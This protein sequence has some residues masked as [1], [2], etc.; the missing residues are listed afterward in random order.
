MSRTFELLRSLHKDGDILP[1]NA[2]VVPP[3]D[4]QP[5]YAS[6]LQVLHP[7][8]VEKSDWWRIVDTLRRHWRLSA[9][10]T[11]I[12]VITAAVV[13]ATMKPVYEPEARIEVTP[14]GAEAFSLQ[15]VGPS[16]DA[17]DYIETN[18]QKLRSDDLA[19]QIIQK[20]GLDRTAR[21]GRPGPEK[22]AEP[23]RP[24]APAETAALRAF[25]RNLT[26]SRDS[27]SHIIRVSFAANDPKLA[28]EVTNSLVNAFID[29]TYRARHT[30][31]VKS[32]DWLSK[33]LDDV[34]RK[35]EQS[36]RALA[37]FQ[38]VNGIAGLDA[39]ANTFT[40]KMAEL[41]R[42][43]AQA[44][45]ERIHYQALLNRTNA[46]AA[47][48][49]PQVGSDPVVQELRKKL[50]DARA[51]LSETLVVYG[52]RNP[53]VRKVND[54]IKELQREL[55]AQQNRIA[56]DVDTSYIAAQ[57]R[58]RLLEQ[59]IRISSKDLKKMAEYE[60]LKKEVQASSELYNKLFE[61]VKE[62]GI[63]A[64]STSTN[65]HF[66]DPARV[67]ISPTRPNRLMNLVAGLGAGLIGGIALAFARDAVDH[68]VRTPEDLKQCTGLSAITIVP[69]IESPNKLARLLPA[70][71]H[72]AQN[73]LVQRPNSPESEAM[74]A[75]YTS[76]QLANPDHPPQVILIGSPNT[77]EGKTTLA[78]NLALA[79]ARHAGTLLID[80][81][82]RKP[83]IARA[84][85]VST[86]WGLRDVLA[87]RTAVDDA[88]VPLPD[89]RSLFLLSE[90][91]D[92]GVQPTD[93]IYS[94][95]A[96]DLV[97]RLREKFDHIVIDSPP[98]LSFADAR[99]L[100][101]LADGVV[102]VGR[103]GIT[104]KES[105]VRSIELLQ[106]S[107]AAP[108]LEVVLNGANVGVDYYNY[109]Y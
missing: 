9:A 35:M 41:N 38:A 7:E 62:A 5:A 95:N 59:Q 109:A 60:A 52:P 28:A 17:S 37:D 103:A 22:Q 92:K 24:E 77:G 31:I 85:S 53:N 97:Q 75:L 94:P 67:L 61:K 36:N 57:S 3:E 30:S 70:R 74:L 33:Q 76:L 42:Q 82:L 43:L 69:V 6:R 55:T 19:M 27:S 12:A 71:N 18:V 49:L 26:V 89:C 87:G 63:A 65:L 73:A 96:A 13:T 15:S 45:A 1:Q 72:G 66:I 83:A 48:N 101:R 104:T 20:F 39:N 11:A 80:A 8:A 10:F 91:T 93:L 44:Q 81:D 29:S 14:P 78:I 105:L 108:V 107:H 34:R 4:K 40:E 51:R 99:A 56:Q 84:V 100:A 64:E 46:E 58:E 106:L 32:S 2:E 98:I 54:S 47:T 25:R 102:L 21:P 68:T 23:D 50:S 88:Y 90:G 86:R 16:S 79:L